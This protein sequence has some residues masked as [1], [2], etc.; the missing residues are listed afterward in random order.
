MGSPPPEG[1]KKDVLIFRSVK[2]IVI[3]PAR[4]GKEST[5]KKVVIPTD[6]T[7]KGIRSQVIPLQRILRIVEIILIE[8]KIEEAPAR[9][10]EKIARSTAD[11][12]WPTY[13]ASGG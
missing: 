9:C 4:T 11:P 12:E 10:K 1:S 2:S 13:E 6:H 7:N 5:N 8:P 3:A